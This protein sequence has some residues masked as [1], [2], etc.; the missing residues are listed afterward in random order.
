MCTDGHNKNKVWFSDTL[1]L[2]ETRSG[3]RLAVSLRE[4]HLPSAD[5]FP[6][7]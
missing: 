4:V 1:P 3:T 6:T 5:A 7:V 2:V